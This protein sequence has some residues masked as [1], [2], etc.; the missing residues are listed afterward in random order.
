MNKLLILSFVLLVLGTLSTDAFA[1]GGDS[2]PL[3]DP[4]SFTATAPDEFRVVFETSEGSFTIEVH[5]EQSPLGADRFFNLVESGFFDGARFFRVVPNFVVQFGLHAVP[6]V[7]Q[8]WRAA[9]IKDDPVKASNTKGTITFATAGPN[10]R[11]TQLFINL[12]DNERLDGMGFSPFG[13]VVEGMDVV[14]KLYSGYGEGAPRGRG[15]NQRQIVMEGNPY[16]ERDFPEL[17]YIKG[18]TVVAAPAADKPAAD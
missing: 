9:S 13:S 14:E 3:L 17:D 8:A 5:R 4:S 11:T 6:E 7:S 18:T 1:K 10:T 15:P 16:L 2:N 12:R